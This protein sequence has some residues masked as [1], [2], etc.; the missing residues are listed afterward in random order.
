LNV[1]NRGSLNAIG[2]TLADTLPKS[3]RLRSARSDHGT[4]R[5]QTRRKVACNFGGFASGESA[6]VT[7][8]VRPLRTGTISNLASVRASQPVDPNPG[9]DSAAQVTTVR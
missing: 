5:A 2:V 9:N 3:A 1:T 4:C 8:M 6:T 7:I